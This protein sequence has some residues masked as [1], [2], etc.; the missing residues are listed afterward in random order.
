MRLILITVLVG[1]FFAGCGK[2]QTERDNELL[3]T[4]LEE[5][6]S[7]VQHAQDMIQSAKSDIDDL[8]DKIRSGNF[9]GILSDLDDI[10]DELDAA[11]S[12]LGSAI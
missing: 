6:R 7:S 12:E 11:E 8:Q 3:R 1:I 9:Y 5:L 2:S 4:Q 10:G